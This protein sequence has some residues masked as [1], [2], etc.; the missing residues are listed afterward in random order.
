[1]G[2]CAQWE[3]VVGEGGLY[4]YVCFKKCL[5][6]FHRRCI[7]KLGHRFYPN[8]DSRNANVFCSGGY[9]NYV[10]GTLLRE[11][12]VSWVGEDGLTGEFQQTSGEFENE[13]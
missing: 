1:M 9:Y 2:S 6:E 8:Y 13:Y 4:E 3:W 12:Y 11:P 10:G 5:E 7:D